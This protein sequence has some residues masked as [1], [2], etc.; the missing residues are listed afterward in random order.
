MDKRLKR[1]LLVII[2]GFS[3]LSVA[4]I[5]KEVVETQHFK[6]IYDK[7]T[8]NAAKELYSF[9]EDAYSELVEFFREDPKL[10][11]PIYINPDEKDYNAYFTSSPYNRIV[12]YD[13]PVSS[14]LDN[15]ENTYYMTFLHELTH[16]FTFS[17]KDGMGEVMTSVFGDWA[18]ISVNLH[19]LLF[20]QEGI[21]V[22]TESRDGGGRLNDPFFLT[23]LTQ[24]RLENRDISYMDASGGRDIMPG[25]SMW[26]LYGGAFTEWMKEKYGERD[27]A[28]YYLKNAKSLF[29]FPQN[30]YSSIFS[31]TLWKDWNRFWND[32]KVPASFNEPEIITEE[33]RY[34][35]NLTLYN[36]NLFALS[37]SKEALIKVGEKEEKVFSFYSSSSDL[38]I[39]K[40]GV[41]L[42]PYVSETV[43]YVALYDKNGKRI[44]KYDG[45][46][47]GTFSSSSIVLAS[48]ID[49]V[50][51]LTV[52]NENG[53]IEKTIELGRDV[54]VHEFT[55]ND[56]GVFFLLS[57]KGEEKIAYL[58]DSSE[59]HLITTPSYFAFSS[60]SG[61]ENI[62]SFSYLDKNIEGLLPKYGEIDTYNMTLRL[63]R[64]EY[65][66]GVNYP[67]RDCDSVFFVS[68]FFDHSAVSKC[69]YESLEVEDVGVMTLTPYVKEDDEFKDVDISSF[70]YKY[71]P[72]STMNKGALI[73]ISFTTSKFYSLPPSIGVSYITED[74]TETHFLLGKLG[75]VPERDS[76]AFGA[77]YSASIFS[78]SFTGDINPD[79]YNWEI[80]GGVSLSFPLS[81][82]GEVIGIE[83]TMGW[84]S[85]DGSKSFL[86]Y[87]S[88]S[89]ENVRQHGIGRYHTLGWGVKAEALNLDPTLTIFA[90]FPQL[91][92][93][94]PLSP[95]DYGVP[96]TLKCSVDLLGLELSSRF[97]VLTYEVQKSVRFLSL[98]FTHLD[99]Y[100]DI[101]FSFLYRGALD[102]QYSLGFTTT[103]SPVLG[104]LSSLQVEIGGELN[105]NKEK[106][107]S[108]KLVLGAH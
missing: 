73:P 104:Q 94:N 9:V 27:I 107:I 53:E 66:G 89:Y 77:Y 51:Y 63:S 96:F 13:A 3:F 52:I 88:L 58:D 57:R 22:F 7:S 10:Y 103:L 34:Y 55:S 68:Q 40:D 93:Y 80:D 20:M 29:S 6:I 11:L 18:N 39:G 50:T 42:L 78:L 37:S 98:Y 32:I 43:S 64:V 47:D 2:L 45:Y 15:T 26:Y 46:Y 108:V 8:E 21:S 5:G 65:N 69:R 30:G 61:D 33:S 81:H 23:P 87:L 101:G 91:F 84:V 25:G 71:N 16:A 4:L 36:G 92:P 86:N 74:A 56:K 54:T 31:N 41:F 38:S 44:K 49:R 48:T 82:S 24:A 12:I 83:D 1:V 70:S 75:Y 67:V 35:S 95:L 62:L 106:G 60:L 79:F 17:F 14:S 28:A 102:S 100:S 105:Y 59:L 72:F 85:L 99:L 76:L 97:H 90:S 19:M